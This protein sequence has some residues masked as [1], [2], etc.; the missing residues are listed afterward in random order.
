MILAWLQRSCS[1]L[2]HNSVVFFH[3]AT[4]SWKDLHDHFDQ[5]DM[6]RIVDLHK[7]IYVEEIF[8]T[9]VMVDNVDMEQY[10]RLMELLQQ[11][12]S[13]ASSY[14]YANTVMDYNTNSLTFNIIPLT[15]FG[16]GIRVATARKQ[17]LEALI[18]SLEQAEG[19][20]IEHAKEAE[21]H[22]SS[23]R[24]ANNDETSGNSV[25]DADEAAS[26]SSSD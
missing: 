2:V 19:E 25:S 21:V 26:S 7:D 22:T 24:S 14:A 20:N 3:T 12:K 10:N 5:G 23:E 6:F 1:P 8:I 16:E 15:S 9:E 17:S 18:A 13:Q 11:S 4:V